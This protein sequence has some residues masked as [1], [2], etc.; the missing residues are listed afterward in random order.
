MCGIL[1]IKGFDSVVQDLYDGLMVLQHRGQDA[2]GILTYSDRFHLKKGNGLARDVFRVEHLMKLKGRMGIG[3]VRYA[4]AGCYDASEAQPFITN[5]PFGIALIH[6]GNLTNCNELRESLTKGNRWY[7]NT[8][9]DSELLLLTLA[10]ELLELNIKKFSPRELFKALEKAYE[11]IKGSYSVIALI[12][13]YGLLAFRD[14]HGI[15]PLCFGKRSSTLGTEYVFASESVALDALGFEFIRDV[16]P[17]EAVFVDN[18]GKAHTA[19]IKPSQWSP[20][21]FEWV[22]LARPRK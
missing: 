21:L 1:G 18:D 15:R 14:P 8:T 11:K 3:H 2:A 6:N 13:D 7:I 9:S 5:V 22:Y 4:T 20:C 19:Q 10:N 17:G 12:A 16:K